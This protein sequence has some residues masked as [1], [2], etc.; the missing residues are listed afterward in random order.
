MTY[1]ENGEYTSWHENGQKSYEATYKVGELDG[2]ETTWFD[3]GQ[4]SREVTFKEDVKEF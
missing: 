2:K 4:K 1:K 3:N